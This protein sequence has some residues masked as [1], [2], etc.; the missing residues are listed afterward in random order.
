MDAR[1]P[2]LGERRNAYVARALDAIERGVVAVLFAW[3]V[4]NILS[5]VVATGNPF[6]LILLAS[7][8]AVLAFVLVRRSTVDITKSPLDWGL[9]FAGTV[10]PLLVMPAP[11]PIISP[12][13]IL[14]LMFGGGALQITAKFFLRRSFGIVAANRGVKIGGPY[15]LIRH[16]M[17]AGY[18][19]TQFGYLLDNPTHWNLAVYSLCWAV[20]IGRILVEERLLLNDQIYREL[21]TRVPYRLIPRIF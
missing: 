16:P 11:A 2:V 5:D 10:I 1:K 15:R 9:G 4:Y 8:S 19:L 14:V 21:V 7:E 18:M 6:S 17:Y 13:F 20:Q 3:F 12:I